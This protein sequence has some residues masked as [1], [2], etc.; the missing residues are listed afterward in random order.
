MP[1]FYN[2]PSQK[3]IRRNLRKTMPKGEAILWRKLRNN[4]ITYKFRRQYGINN[5]IVDFYCPK[6]RLAVEI[7][8]I[9]HEDPTVQNKDK[10]K[11]FLLKKHEIRILRIPS[12]E[13]FENL[14]T[15]IQLIYSECKK[16]DGE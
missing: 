5:V 4:Q 7:D 1:N 14:D 10:K 16:I 9:T 13:I 8:G 2:K 6:L 11:T 15:V 3:Q 12:S